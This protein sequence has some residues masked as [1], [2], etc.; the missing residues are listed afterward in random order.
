[1]NVQFRWEI[2]RKLKPKLDQIG[3]FRP[4]KCSSYNQIKPTYSLKPAT[5]INNFS[6]KTLANQE[7]RNI[8]VCLSEL[9][10]IVTTDNRQKLTS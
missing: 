1:M 10:S 8:I 9:D 4:L 6:T 7:T 5:K 2:K 3:L